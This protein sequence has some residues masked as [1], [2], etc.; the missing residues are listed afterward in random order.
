MRGF[1]DTVCLALLA[2]GVLCGA[3]NVTADEGTGAGRLIET[4]AGSDDPATRAAAAAALGRLDAAD[5]EATGRAVTVLVEVLGFD[6][7]FSMRGHAAEALGRLGPASEE[8]VQA[9][10]AALEWDTHLMVRWRAAE[11]LQRI[12]AQFPETAAAAVPPLLGALANDPAPGVRARAA[13]ALGA[14]DPGA[15]AVVPALVQAFQSDAHPGVRWQAAAA[16]ELLAEHYAERG[17]AAAVGALRGAEAALAA[18]PH[19]EVRSNAQGL[20]QSLQRLEARSG[21]QLSN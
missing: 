2:G 5:A 12:A 11:A 17:E 19:P 3:G 21:Q 14:V 7:D 13:E 18:H 9:L 15:T 6:R 16:V 10:A 20:R 4:V 8:V 1:R